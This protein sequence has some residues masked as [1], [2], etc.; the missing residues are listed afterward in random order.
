MILGSF[1]F[2]RADLDRRNPR[3]RKAKDLKIARIGVASFESFPLTAEMPPDRA[4]R[5]TTN[6]RVWDEQVHVA[7]L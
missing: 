2:S 6:I 3:L 1:Q 5:A 4:R 7:S